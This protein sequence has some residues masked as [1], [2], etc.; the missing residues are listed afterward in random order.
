MNIRLLEMRN[1]FSRHIGERSHIINGRQWGVIDVGNT[2]PALLML[3]GTL[4]RASIFW[5]Q[6]E[7]LKARARVISVSYPACHNL[8]SWA[9]DI[10]D[11]LARL[12]IRQVTVMGSSLGGYLAQYLASKYPDRIKRLIAANT[13]SSVMG[14]E[15]KQPYASDLAKMPITMLRNGFLQGLQ[16]KEATQPDERE[17]YSL[18][19]SEVVGGISARHLRARLMVL[20]HA[21]PIPDIR[22]SRENIV[23]IESEDDP[24]IAPVVQKGVREFLSPSVVYRFRTGG[25]F[26]YVMRPDVYLSILEEQLGLPTTGADWGGGK[27]RVL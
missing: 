5:Q 27:E 4:G 15:Q 24:L 11:L 22:I 2:G 14:L 3:P 16:E 25:H 1:Q 8:G 13:L 7:A 6:I 23:V 17:L 20:K 26:P 21:P 10:V 9:I 12:D 19:R 18:L